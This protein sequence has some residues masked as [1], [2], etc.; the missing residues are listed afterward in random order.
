MKSIKYVSFVFLLLILSCKEA[1]KQPD[2]S[3]EKSLTITEKIAHAHGFESWKKVNSLKFTFNVDK[4]STHFE[5]SWTWKPKSNEVTSMTSQDTLVYNRKNMDS[6]IYKINAGFINDRYWLLAP[7]NLIWD[8]DNYTYE[9][10]EKA[11]APISKQPLQKLT[12]V[13]DTEGGYTP[14]DAYDFYFGDDFLLQE[15]VFRKANQIEPSMVT[16][17]ENYMEANSLKLA[18]DHKMPNGDFNLHFSNI[19]IK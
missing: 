17:W 14:G 18:L 4:D 13:Y 12:I 3:E 8:A 10:Q 2:K 9:H 5:R 1:K 15:W 7:F 19:A 16:T 6:V 11:T